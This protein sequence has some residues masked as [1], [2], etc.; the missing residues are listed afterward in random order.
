MIELD[1]LFVWAEPGGPEADRLA[2][3]GLNEGPAN[4]HPGQGTACRRFFFRNAYLEV[5]WVCDVEATQS[6]IVGTTGLWKR[7]CGRTAGASPFG[8]CLR[9]AQPG[10]QRVPFAAWEY[11]PEY[12]PA[13]LT[14]HV[15]QD[16]PEREPLWFFLGVSGPRDLPSR[17]AQPLDHP[18]KLR[19]I[20]AVRFQG[21]GLGRPSEVARS[22]TAAWAVTLA[23]A[24]KH[25][26][27][28]TFDGGAQGRTV[29][30]RPELPL[31][32]RW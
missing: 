23:E 19:E 21:P 14:I 20:T 27:E 6:E 4:S 18:A 16:V 9:P 7:W 10:Q 17:S 1:H 30:F 31:L 22:V 24:P 3:F 13:N 11:H 32:F 8:L 5:L 2:A 28:I 29:D 15:G 12:L 25:F 26:A